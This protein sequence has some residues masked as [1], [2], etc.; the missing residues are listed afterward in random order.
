MFLT[1]VLV[2]TGCRSYITAV[3]NCLVFLTQHNTAQNSLTH[4]HCPGWDIRPYGFC[5]KKFFPR[6]GYYPG[7]CIGVVGFKPF[8]WWN[9]ASVLAA[10]VEQV[11]IN[12]PWSTAGSSMQFDPWSEI[13]WHVS[14][15]GH[16]TM[17]G[18][19][20]LGAGGLSRM[21]STPKL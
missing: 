6:S 9:V 16:F 19:R 7:Y 11:S 1:V 3:T 4:P 20:I 14:L 12:C 5:S 2:R 13:L 8:D 15:Q 17:T 10:V 18:A 21:P